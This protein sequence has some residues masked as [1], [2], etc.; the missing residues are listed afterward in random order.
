M[1]TACG[2]TA[3]T[4]QKGERYVKSI[5]KN[6]RISTGSGS[7]NR[8]SRY[9]MALCESSLYRS[10]D[11]CF[12]PVQCFGYPLSQLNPLKHQNKEN[13]HGNYE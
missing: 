2:F 5:S 13:E 8:N 11:G 1:K 9:W 3:N 6:G 12:Y 7:N 10:S 4:K